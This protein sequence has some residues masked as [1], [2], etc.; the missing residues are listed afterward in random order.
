MHRNYYYFRRQIEEIA[1]QLHGRYINT[2]LILNNTD[3]VLEL[4][5]ENNASRYLVFIM[6]VQTPALLLE[7][8]IDTKAP[9]LYTYSLLKFRPINHISIQP[10]DKHIQLELDALT[11]HTIFFGKQF[12]FIIYDQNGEIVDAFNRPVLRFPLSLTRGEDLS[13]FSKSNLPELPGEADYEAL[14]IYVQSRF[15]AVNRTLLNEIFFR[16]KNNAGNPANVLNKVAKELREGPA[17]LYYKKDRVNKLSIVRL[18]HLEAEADISF[19]KYDSVN[20]AWIAFVYKRRFQQQFDKLYQKCQQ[21]LDKRADS[22][23]KALAKIEEVSD[24]EKRK[25]E[26]EI[27]GHLLLTFQNKIPAGASQVKLDNIFS[28]KEEKVTIKLNPAKSISEN[29]QRYF[30]KYKDIL[31]MKS[32]QSIKKGTYTAELQEIR[33][34]QKNLKKCDRMPK[35]QALY[36]ECKNRN[37]IQQQW[38]GQKTINSSIYAFNRIRIDKD[39]EI[40]VGKSGPQN[41]RLTFEVARKQ[42]IWLHAQGV[43]GAHV[44]LRVPDRNKKP[45]MRIIEQAAAIAAA[46]SKALHSGTVPVVYTEVRHVQRIRKAAPGTVTLRNEKT[47]FVTPLNLKG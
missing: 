38:P 20:K 22:L 34:L 39:W 13:S 40:L 27:K 26:A 32:V 17:Y 24:L 23:Q 16:L 14:K 43:A 7:N 37:L 28:E 45:P 44:I 42:D 8:H 33:Q 1:P 25:Q 12:N 4:S 36:K 35:L 30:N 21:A 6:D 18:L 3:I 29:A 10:F 46:N 19:K 47:L 2:V 31:R 15:E 9:R 11:I 41:D 5:S